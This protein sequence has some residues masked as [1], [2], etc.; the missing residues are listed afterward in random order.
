MLTIKEYTGK[1]CGVCKSIKPV[2][3]SIVKSF[4]DEISF[5]EIDI[6]D[7]TDLAK[8]LKISHLPTFIFEKDGVEIHR[9]SGAIN[10]TNFK[11]IINDKK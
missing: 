6:T 5:E 4:G 9:Q 3:T 7:N 8:E 1:W 11:K 10:P 2:V